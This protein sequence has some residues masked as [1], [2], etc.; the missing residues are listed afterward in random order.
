MMILVLTFGDCGI[1]STWIG[2]SS[3]FRLSS[4]LSMMAV[5]SSLI[6]SFSSSAIFF[7][8]IS[9]SNFSFSLSASSFSSSSSTDSCLATSFLVASSCFFSFFG[10]LG[11]FSLSFFSM[12]VVLFSNFTKTLSDV[13]N[14]SCLPLALKRPING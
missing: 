1:V 12:I 10:F 9:F 8:S 3:S 5:L 14:F 4:A 2:S 7:S 6:V 11:F 13:K